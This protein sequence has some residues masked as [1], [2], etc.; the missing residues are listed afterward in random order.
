MISVQLKRLDFTDA[1][2]PEH[3]TGRAIVH[4]LLS[5]NMPREAL[6]IAEQGPQSVVDHVA[7]IRLARNTYFLYSPTL[8]HHFNN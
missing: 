4:L 1:R 8:C 5:L 3:A 6:I 7:A 2:F